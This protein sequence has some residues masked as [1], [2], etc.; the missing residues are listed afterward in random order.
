[1]LNNSEEKD[2]IQNQLCI[3]NIFWKMQGGTLFLSHSVDK[4]G[5]VT[6]CVGVLDDV[7][8]VQ[9]AILGRVTLWVS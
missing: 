5:C 2:D 8:G 4:K 7:A 6:Q 3:D 1:M 9:G